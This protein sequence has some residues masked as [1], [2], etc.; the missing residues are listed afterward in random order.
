MIGALRHR[1][2][3][4]EETRG[5][6]AG[7]G[8][9]LTWSDIATV[10]GRVEPLTGAERL[11]AMRLESRVSHRV[12]IRHRT[13]VSAGM[14]LLHDGRALNIRTVIDPDERRHWLELMCEE[15][16]AT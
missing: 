10:W 14:R 2:A 7:G 1:L 9:T 13:G 16:V 3:L 4:Q 8:Y 5:A 6:D 11:Q 15:G 12:T